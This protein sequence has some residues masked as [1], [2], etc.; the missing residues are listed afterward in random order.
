MTQLK[1]V[2]LELLDIEWEGPFSMPYNKAQQQYEISTI[3][4]E[5]LSQFGLY[6]IY[7]R[8]HVYGANVLLYIGATCGSDGGV[9]TYAN[10]LRE[11][12][13]DRFYERTELSVYLGPCAHDRKTILLAESIL[14]AAHSPALNRNHV[15][16]SVKHERRILIRNWDFIGSLSPMCSNMWDDLDSDE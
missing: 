14:I 5:L 7:G 12:L 16:W 6:Q 1:T 10:R 11:H 8:H 9:R 3:P 15:D 4:L 2:K 13:S